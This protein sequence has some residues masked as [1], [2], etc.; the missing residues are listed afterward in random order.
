MKF[1]MMALERVAALT[2][3]LLILETAVDLI[4]LRTPAAAF[5]ASDELSEDD[6][7]WWG[8]NP[9][10]LHGMLHAVGFA[11]VET[12]C[13]PYPLIRRL[14]HAVESFVRKGKNPFQ[15]CQRGRVTVH[16]RKN[17]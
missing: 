7:N 13:H 14:G 3:D 5:Y 17:A 12:V 1:P 11:H 8:P 4:G 16:A 9:A 10:A 15:V 2:D 6:T